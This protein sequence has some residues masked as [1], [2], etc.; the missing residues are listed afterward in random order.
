MTTATAMFAEIDN[1]QH[2]MRLISES[3]SY[4]PNLT[5]YSLVTEKAS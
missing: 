5:L 3:L 4:A 2:L 1:F